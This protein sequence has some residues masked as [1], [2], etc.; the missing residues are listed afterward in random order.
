MKQLLLVSCL[1]FIL[2]IS[3]LTAQMTNDFYQVETIQTP[4][5]IASEVSAITFTRDGRLA[6]CFRRGTIA[7]MDPES[8]QW[9]IFAS[10]LD[11]PLGIVEGKGPSEFYVVQRPELT[12][13]ADL[14]GD[15]VADLYQTVCDDWG[16]SGNYHEFAF[17]LVQDQDENFY[18]TL[19]L[20]S[21]LQGVRQPVRGELS[22][23][24]KKIG[25]FSAVK[26]RGWVLKISPDGVAT[27]IACG[28]RQPNGLG[29]NLEGDIF[30]TDNQGDFVAASPLYH[31]TP[32]AFFGQPASLVWEPGFQGDPMKI[33]S[34]KLKRRRKRPAIE[35]PYGDLSSSAA[36]PLCDRTKG[37]FGPYAGQFM[38]AEFTHPRIVRA[39]LEIVDGEY[40]G[41]CFP[42]LDQN[43]LRKG[44]VRLAFAPDGNLYVAQTA[45]GWVGAEGLQR[46]TWTGKVPM[47]VLKMSLKQDG[48]ELTFTHPLD[49]ATAS[50]PAAY[51]VQHYYYHYHPTYGSPKVDAT[52]VTISGVSVSEDKK[53]VH[54][55]LPDLKTERNYQ[56]TFHGLQSETKEPLIIPFAVYTLNR[57]RA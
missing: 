10:G 25:Q 47:D 33:P 16:V 39:A 31:V 18:V 53:R 20:A 29:R 24:M 41:A 30:I 2:H 49:S 28:L 11:T 17:G 32:G 43:G 7:L 48:F 26:Y 56:V 34:E 52:P 6:A 12:R 15:G 57:L 27:P 51:A 5:G 22:D 42:F 55:I 46:V 36:E 9:K 14:D 8:R 23:S 4:E 37:K 50:D 3:D 19:S 13:V 38:I 1:A 40:Q 21:Q 45:R 54:L 35:M 44:N